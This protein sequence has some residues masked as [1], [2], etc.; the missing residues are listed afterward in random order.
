MKIINLMEDT[1]G[2]QGVYAE[3]GLCIYAKTKNHQIL[4]DT[5]ASEK[6]WENAKKFYPLQNIIPMQKSIFMPVGAM[7][8]II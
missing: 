6:T 3:H 8:I 4:V 2:E 7:I 5:G 1:M